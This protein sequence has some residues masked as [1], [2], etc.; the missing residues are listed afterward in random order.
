MKRNRILAAL[1][2]LTLVLYVLPAMAQSIVL[3]FLPSEME[4][5]EKELT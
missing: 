2:A 3:F 5:T 4:W 1:L